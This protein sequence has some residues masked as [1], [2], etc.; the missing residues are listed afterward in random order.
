[1]GCFPAYTAPIHYKKSESNVSTDIK[2][3][4]VYKKIYI[5]RMRILTPCDCVTRVHL[6]S[7]YDK[8]GEA[9]CC[10]NTEEGY[11][12]RSVRPRKTFQARWCLTALPEME[13]DSSELSLLEYWVQNREKSHSDHMNHRKE[14]LPHNA[15]HM[16]SLLPSLFISAVHNWA[17]MRPVWPC[18]YIQKWKQNLKMF[19][20]RV[21]LLNKK[22]YTTQ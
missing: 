8:W 7:A 19:I 3:H 16:S 17:P 9:G 18:S 13:P 2:F 11:L 10:R 21:V 20:S 4:S 14:L 6:F 1:M 5:W 22:H 12:P 15:A